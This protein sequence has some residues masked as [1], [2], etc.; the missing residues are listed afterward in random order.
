MTD[1][2]FA[3]S[4]TRNAQTRA[5]VSLIFDNTDH[6]LNSEFNEIEIKRVVY[7]TGENEYYINNTKVRLK[8]ITDLFLDSGAGKESFNIIGQGEIAD[9]ISSKPDDRRVIFEEAAAVLKYKKR[10]EESF[11]KLDR[12]NENLERVNMLIDELLVT[13]TPLKEQS[14]K[15]RVYLDYKKDLENIE[16]ALIA[17]DITALNE[18]YNV[19]KEKIDTLNKELE[20]LSLSNST[21]TS[22]LEELKLENLKL[23]SAIEE[24]NSII[25]SLTQE[26]A[27]LESKKSSLETK[28]QNIR[29]QYSDCVSEH[30]KAKLELENMSRN[31]ENSEN[32][33]KE[34]TE[35]IAVSEPKISDLNKINSKKKIFN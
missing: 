24:K 12:T 31:Y 8:D 15:A 35:F 17:N 18:E 7:K 2:I 34:K 10:K 1:V 3:G 22:K 32:I 6:Y 29:Q 19:S 5:S 16:I 25:Y 14:E 27:D 9:I 33:L 20:K 21:D 13:L 28:L 11:R 30:S 26:I 4:K 23:D